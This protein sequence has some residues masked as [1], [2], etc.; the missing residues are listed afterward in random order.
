MATDNPITLL[1]NLFLSFFQKMTPGYWT[2]P[3]GKGRGFSFDKSDFERTGGTARILNA[4]GKAKARKYYDAYKN[5]SKATILGLNDTVLSLVSVI[6]QAGIDAWNT[7]IST[8]A[9][10]TGEISRD[11]LKALQDWY[12]QYLKP[13]N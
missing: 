11:G 5:T 8:Y 4:A 6:G 7:W 10:G 13:L 3:E 2:N 9:G 1:K 12:N